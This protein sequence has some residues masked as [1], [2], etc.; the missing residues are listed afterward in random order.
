[1]NFIESFK[2]YVSKHK[3]YMAQKHMEKPSIVVNAFAGP[4]AGKTVS[5][6][7]LAAELAKKGYVTEYVS[8][9]AKEL[10]WDGNVD[11][12]NGEPELQLAV[13]QE[14][15][16]RIDRIYGSVDFIVC[17]SPIMLNPIY[18]AEA[19]PEY[20]ALTYDLFSQYNNFCYFVERDPARYE[21]SGRLQN[22][23]ESIAIDNEI[24]TML[25]SQNIYF[26][27]YNHNT[28]MTVLNNIIKYKNRIDKRVE[29]RIQEQQQQAEA[30]SNYGTGSADVSDQNSSVSYTHQKKASSDNQNIKLTK[31]V[32]DTA[33]KIIASGEAL[34]SF[35][36]LM[37]RFK[38]YS[39]NNLLLIYAQNP[40]ASDLKTFD[41]W[42]EQ[43]KHLKKGVKGTKI[44]KK[45]N[46]SNS[47]TVVNLFDVRQ[48]REEDMPPIPVHETISDRNQMKHF[49]KLMANG[50]APS[51]KI[52]GES[53]RAEVSLDVLHGEDAVYNVENKVIYIREDL[54]M[55]VQL[56]LICRESLMSYIA[57]R[58][59]S[60]SREKY[61]PECSCAALIVCERYGVDASFFL[62]E[63][64]DY[65]QSLPKD[66]TKAIKQ[67]I[68]NI[69][70][71][72]N[73]VSEI[74]YKNSRQAEEK[75]E[76]EQQVN[77]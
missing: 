14:Q 46:G 25:S 44:R 16:H 24:K 56:N 37:S 3:E 76:P 73:T 10:V 20:M 2:N 40:N 11:L 77:M 39:T 21:Q 28:I 54:P 71:K 68:D 66:D 6:L 62:S 47:F 4:G 12:L 61:I 27:I 69:R 8:E 9:Y 45:E 13:L 29:S 72:S 23:N 67:F 52:A 70:S 22:M 63:L 17:D 65:C 36:K 7:T 1:M 60:Y 30:P 26:G 50:F 19:N 18:L 74:I 15:V 41:E 75:S 55:S 35:L 31:M 42:H 57:G 59:K 5:A 34:Y 43:G 48:L 38:D 53:K 51:A 32:T 33:T 58:D 64:D 49:F